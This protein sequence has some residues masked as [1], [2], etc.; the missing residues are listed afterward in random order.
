MDMIDKKDEALKLAAELDEMTFLFFTEG[1][2]QEAA[3]ELRRLHDVECNRDEWKK[4]VILANRRFKI[5]EEKLDRLQAVNNDLLEALKD[6][7]DALTNISTPN[8][9]VLVKA[10]AAIAKAT[11]EQ[12]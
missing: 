8:S 2:A 11:G 3:A 4:G 5:A 6:V 12:A 10:R 1:S 7:A 9:W